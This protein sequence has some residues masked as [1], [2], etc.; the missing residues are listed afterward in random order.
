M[1]AVDF[2]IKQHAKA[3]HSVCWNSDGTLLLLGSQDNTASLWIAATAE[4]KHFTEIHDDW[5]MSVAFSQD[6]ELLAIG[7]WDKSVSVITIS[8]GERLQQL[9]PGGGGVYSVA[10]RPVPAAA[11]G[12]E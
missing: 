11:Q 6:G 7:S 4:H 2:I 5:V 9:K 12:A 8:T 3:V 10:F 1:K